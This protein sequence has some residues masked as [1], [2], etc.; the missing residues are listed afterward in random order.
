MGRIPVELGLLMGAVHRSQEV[1]GALLAVV[2][3]VA[4]WGNC[5][6]V[7]GLQPGTLRTGVLLVGC[8]QG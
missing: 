6:E 2:A 1:V 4:C 7:G 5:P 8:N 3:G